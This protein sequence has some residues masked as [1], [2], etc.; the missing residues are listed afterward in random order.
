MDVFAP[1]F[2]YSKAQ[3]STPTRTEIPFCFTDCYENTF[4]GATVSSLAP[5]PS[6]QYEQ[7]RW[8]QYWHTSTSAMA[9]MALT[10]ADDGA[11]Y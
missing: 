1:L 4:Y 9:T 6:N 8:Q 11:Q 3:I 7:Q 2:R 10:K 5:A